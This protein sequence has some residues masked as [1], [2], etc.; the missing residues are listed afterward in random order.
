M[1]PAQIFLGKPDPTIAFCGSPEIASQAAGHAL[2]SIVDL[3]K[4]LPAVIAATHS[5]SSQGHVTE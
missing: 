5:L 2:A 1:Q 3:Y 4:L